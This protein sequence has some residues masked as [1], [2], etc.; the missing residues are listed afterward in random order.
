MKTI[1][2]I[3]SLVCVCVLLF[4]LAVPFAVSTS[5]AGVTFTAI[6]TY[7]TESPINKAPL[8]FEAKINIPAS[9]TGRAG[10]IFGN[11]NKK[12]ASVN[13]EIYSNGIPRFYAWASSSSITELEFT[14]VHVNTGKDVHLAITIDVAAG[15]AH[16]YV[17]GEVAQTLSCAGFTGLVSPNPYMVGGDLRSANAQYFKGSISS[18]SV[19][20]DCRTAAEVNADMKNVD[21][22]DEDLLVSYDLT[23]NAKLT[24]RSKNSND[25]IYDNPQAS[26]DGGFKL[27]DNAA[28]TMV[29]PYEA[30]PLTYEAW[31]NVPAAYSDRGGVIVGNYGAATPCLSFEIHEDGNPRFYYV[32]TAENKR[33]VIFDQVDVRTGTWAHVAIVYDTADNN[34]KCYLNGVLKQTLTGYGVIDSASYENAFG[35]AGD[36]RSGNEQYFKGALKSVTL[37]SDVRTADEIK[38]DMS[39]VNVNA[40]AL[41]AHYDVSDGS[42][43]EN[44]KDLSPN[45]C[46]VQY[47]R[48]WFKDK[49]PVTDY[50]YSFCVVGDTQ[51]VAYLYPDKFHHIYDWI[52]ANKE[53]K[54]IEFVFGLGDI[55]DKDTTAE[56]DLV[57]PEIFKLNGVVPYSLVRGNHDG[58]ANFNKY[59]NVPEY[60]N[61]LGGTMTNVN[62]ENSWQTFTAGGI[63]Y[64]VLTLDYGASDAILNWAAGIIEAHPNHRVIITTHAYLFRD[65]TTL[66]VGDVVPPNKTGA[67]D[68]VKNNGDQM[69]DKLVSKYENIF[70]VLSGHDPC[71]NIIVAQDTG[72][73]GNIV[74]QFLVDPQ[75]VDKAQGATGM[76]AMLYFSN[77]G[78]TITV[79]NYSTVRD[80]FY[81]STSQMTIDISGFVMGENTENKTDETTAAPDNDTEAPENTTAVVEETPNVTEPTT[82]KKSCGSF[83]L[84]A[85]V[86]LPLCFVAFAFGKKKYF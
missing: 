41:L 64:L 25:L 66:D 6:E 11:Y 30:A 47:I 27:T 51:K 29:K 15:K 49:E 68:G 72:V 1:K 73:H 17:D 79:E 8:T 18:V 14:N 57:K 81:M 3:L 37:Y 67:N 32:D 52:V 9:V 35:F 74:T 80:E 62:M 43:G 55:T 38:A 40:D 2:K 76:V 21:T 56:W 22:N 84:S 75:G 86:I 28:Y 44:V 65:G 53:S 70:L 31:V 34:I 36:L 20:S 5:A 78:K 59:F 54:K 4:S 10:V 71:D 7:T 83:T 85:A 77:D 63:D 48:T 33:S 16:C 50:A 42:T 60:R 23:T 45:G 46:D 26:I 19:F 58:S 82:E 61:R 39:A 69:W 12:Q 13:F 24:D